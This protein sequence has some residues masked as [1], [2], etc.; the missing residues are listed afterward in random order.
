MRIGLNLCAPLVLFMFCAS[1][2]AQV[3]SYIDERGVRVFTNIAPAT[4]VT[5]L[6]VSCAPPAPSV[7][8]MSPKAPSNRTSAK[9]KAA[10]PGS[11]AG[12]S[13]QAQNGGVAVSGA[14]SVAADESESGKSDYS[15]IIA[16]YSNEFGVDPKLIH[17]MIKTESSFNPTAVSPKGAQGLMQLMPATASRLGVR[18]PFDPDENIRGGIQ[19]MR[20]LL[21]MFSYSPDGLKLSLAAYNAGENLVMRLGRVPAI[22]ETNDYVRSILER[23]GQTQTQVFSLAQQT[24]AVA[25]PMMFRY[26]DENG[27][28]VYTNIPP[29]KSANVKVSGGTPLVFR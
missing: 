12:G 10:S 20:S 3:Y 1:A 11:K 2:Y 16:K 7:A 18:K 13:I 23:Y 15:A 27:V 5:D 8:T 21:D 19:H 22:R 26:P 29:V 24:V 17:S 14:A 25:A 9:P 6:K 4:P 28:L